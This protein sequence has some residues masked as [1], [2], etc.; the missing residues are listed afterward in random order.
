MKR[1]IYSKPLAMSF[2]LSV[3]CSLLHVTGLASRLLF[4]RIDKK[5]VNFTRIG[6]ESANNRQ[7]AFVVQP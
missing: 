1:S 5:I 2:A 6:M 3:P 4:F 7:V